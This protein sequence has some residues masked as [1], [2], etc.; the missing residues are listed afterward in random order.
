MK[1]KK[2]RKR[3]WA[4]E[5][6]NWVKPGTGREGSKIQSSEIVNCAVG[7]ELWSL[8]SN[9]SVPTSWYLLKSIFKDL[10]EHNFICSLR[11]LLYTQ[12]GRKYFPFDEC[13][14]S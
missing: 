6:G 7:R 9:P 10:I 13:Q 12:K 8:I 1:K 14:A 3:K 4:M 5:K 2:E 11:A